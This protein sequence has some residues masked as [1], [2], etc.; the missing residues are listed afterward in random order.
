MREPVHLAR[1]ARAAL[2]LMHYENIDE[3]IATLDH[4]ALV[5]REDA[6]CVKGC[7]RCLLSYYNQPDHESI[8]RTDSEVLTL[9]LRIARAEMTPL[10]SQATED[11]V[12]T[13]W[14]AALVRWKLPT[15]TSINL[16]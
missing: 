2:Q 5:D 10:A 11:S 13:G 6:R 9:L 12:S 16:S 3:A 8:D 4:N 1:I 7:Y 14:R 15:P